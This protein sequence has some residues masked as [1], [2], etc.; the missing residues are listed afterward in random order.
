MGFCVYFVGRKDEGDRVQ[1][2]VLCAQDFTNRLQHSNVVS[3]RS[4]FC[5]KQDSLFHL[6]TDVSGGG[7]TASIAAS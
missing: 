6:I 5:R 1:A 3:L 7:F 4:E 2:T